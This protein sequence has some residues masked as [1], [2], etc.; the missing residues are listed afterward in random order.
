M[1]KD[2]GCEDEDDEPEFPEGTP[3]KTVKLDEKEKEPCHNL[4]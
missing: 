2:C 4:T 1:C 3:K